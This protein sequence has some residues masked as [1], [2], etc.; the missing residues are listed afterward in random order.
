MLVL[1]KDKL[2]KCSSFRDKIQVLTLCPQEWSI[3]AASE[4]FSVSNYLII[5]SRSLAKKE[6]VLAVPQTKRGKMLPD[7]INTLVKI[8]YENDENSRQMPGQKDFVSVS[9]KVHMQ[10]RLLLSSL[11]E[12]FV[13]FKILYPHVKLGFSKFCVLRPKWCVLPNSSG[14][15]SVCVCIYHQ[16]MKLILL[17][18]KIDY[19]KLYKFIVC[20][21]QN[22]ECMLHRCTQCPKNT[23]KLEENLFKLIGQFEEEDTIEFNQWVTTDRSDLVIQLV[24][25]PDY[26]NMVMEK[27]VK[28]TTHSY[29]SKCQSKYFKNLK[30]ELPSGS[31]IILGDFAEN[32]SFVVQ[33][34]VQGFHWN[35]L[36]CTLH[37]VVVYYKENQVLHST[38]YCIIS[39]DNTHDVPMVYEVQKS[40]INNL[41]Q[42]IPSIVNV[43]YFSDGCSSQYKNC[44]NIFN[45]CQHKSDFGIDAKRVFFATSHGKQPC[46]GIGGTVKRLVANASLQ[47]ISTN[48]IL[49]SRDMFT[50]CTNN[51]KGINFIFISSE[52]LIETRL[53][54]SERFKNVKTI[55]GTRDFHEFIPVCH[56][57][58]KMK[59]CSDDTIPILI[60][61]FKNCEMQSDVQ[62]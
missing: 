51:I 16:N 56:N 39:D 40:I 14:T 52:S 1:I 19:H 45:L 6:G 54:Q 60:Y 23:S 46:D 62:S 12:L 5:K 3:K 25:I 32:Y 34:E 31:A 44:K 10:K 42:K 20:D 11:K 8:F 35:N 27:L 18:I 50:Y 9:W 43:V 61:K 4:Y 53:L 41:K 47:R 29:I 36:Q 58:V 24:T 48:Q 17:P 2:E 59:Y 37:P 49:N 55:P 26:V 38:S 30:E 57:E 33:D 22:K 7:Q 28:L 15:H 21:M 13:S